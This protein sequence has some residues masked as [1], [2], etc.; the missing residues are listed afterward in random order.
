MFSVW[1]ENNSLYCFCDSYVLLVG[2]RD[3][4]D[5]RVFGMLQSRDVLRV[6]LR[7]VEEK[8]EDGM[9]RNLRRLAAGCIRCMFKDSKLDGAAGEWLIQ[10]QARL[11]AACADEG[12]CKELESFL[13]QLVLIQ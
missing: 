8:G 6:L 13:P 4:E 7:I 12:V 5:K 9:L 10:H 3:H 11:F 1:K 2:A